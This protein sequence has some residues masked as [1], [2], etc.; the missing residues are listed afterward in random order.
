[1]FTLVI[2]AAGSGKSEYAEGLLI[3]GQESGKENFLPAAEKLREEE[4]LTEKKNSLIYIATMQPWDEECLKRIEK[5]RRA[6]AGKGFFTIERYLDLEG[7]P[8]PKG[9][10]VLLECLS[11]LMANE[12]YAPEGGG[13]EAVLRGTDALLARCE[14]LVIVTNE[15]FSGGSKY[16]GD[17]LNYLRELAAANRALAQ[18]ADRV[19]EV[20]C[21]CPN[22]LK[23]EEE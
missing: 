6:R 14:E 2:G 16:E 9:S 18:K 11:N 3:E 5:H 1:M 12:L 21:G 19:I 13:R 23:G 20:V 10:R 17:S 8:L 22:I 7:L 15:V 4:Y